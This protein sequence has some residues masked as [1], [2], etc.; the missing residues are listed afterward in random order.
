VHP[1]VPSWCS[2][3]HPCAEHLVHS[4]V[5]QH[6]GKKGGND[7][8][9]HRVSMDTRSRCRA[10]AHLNNEDCIRPIFYTM[11]LTQNTLLIKASHALEVAK[12]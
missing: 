6:S 5:C 9:G 2:N 7:A 12:Q 4:G 8:R 1:D 11:P 3:F 10:R